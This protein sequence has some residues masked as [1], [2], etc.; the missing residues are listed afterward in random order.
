MV[1]CGSARLYGWHCVVLG[2]AAGSAYLAGRNV[3]LRLGVPDHGGYVAGSG[4]ASVLGLA[5]TPA[6]LFGQESDWAAWVGW[7]LI[8]AAV[9][10]TWG[11]LLVFIVVFPL[12]KL[13]T[14]R[15]EDESQVHDGEHLS[16]SS[17][18]LFRYF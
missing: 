7:N 8:G 15:Q 14:L 9:L 11:F 5:V 18:I 10:T 12:Q 1:A 13:Q 3:L 2:T 17:L 6:I 4:A 16:R